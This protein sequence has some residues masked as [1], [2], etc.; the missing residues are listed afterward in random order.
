M[1]NL[2]KTDKMSASEITRYYTEVH[3]NA[4]AHDPGDPLDA[5]IASGE[6]R[7]VIR[8]KDF[9]H[10]QGMKKAFA[11][12]EDEMGSLR[13]R[14]VLD[15]GCGRGRWS[16]EYASRGALVTGV[17][18]SPDAIQLVAH[19]Q[20]QHRFLCGDLASLEFAGESFDMVNSVT[21]LQHMPDAR[22][23]TVLGRIGAWLKPGGCLVLLESLV[24]FGAPHVFPHR[25]EEWIA[26]AERAGLKCTFC[27]GSNFEVLF[28][29]RARFL[30]RERLA[31]EV[32]LPGAGPALPPSLIKTGLKS[33]V[34][35]AS[36]PLEWCCH[37]ARL[38]TP[39]HSVMVFL[40]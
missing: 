25:T 19:E 15:L 38:A 24:G 13:G 18:I 12:L 32:F 14:S 37:R 10:R 33:A 39:T 26:M 5:V 1:N 30:R 17:D 6:N 36:F 9:A 3:R 28:V 21:V 7:W 2:G 23:R 4:L 16:R 29:M 11:A 20:P 31:R 8:F 35:L 34:A 40:K 22:Q 27:C